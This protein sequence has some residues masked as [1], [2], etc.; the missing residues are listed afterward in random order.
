[1][2]QGLTVRARRAVLTTAIV[3]AAVV[4]DLLRAQAPE[5]SSPFSGVTLRRSASP[6]ANPINSG[7]RVTPDGRTVTGMNLTMR[8]MIRDAFGLQWRPSRLVVGG[9]SWLDS[10]RYDLVATMR[11]PFQMVPRNGGL[12]PEAEPLLEALF[13]DRVKVRVRRETV[14]LPVYA[15]TLAGAPGPGLVKAAA[16]C[17]GAFALLPVSPDARRALSLCPFSVTPGQG[18]GAI[19]NGTTMEELTRMLALYPIVDRV[20]IDRTGLEGPYDIAFRSQPAFAQ[21]PD[22]LVPANF[23]RPGAVLI[24]QAIQ[25]QLGLT[26]E[27]TI[28]PMMRL[29][30]EHAEPPALD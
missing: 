21:T 27:P 3:M 28:A 13:V 24:P 17:L 20:V 5:A 8:E 6:G 29:V 10:D 16:P 26:L 2:R 25:E 9:P 11:Q 18:P 30:V 22:G 23:G 19:F 7:L 12:P 4:P 14:N 1:M 15:L